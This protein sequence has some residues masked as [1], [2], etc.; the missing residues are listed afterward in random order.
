MITRF[1]VTLGLL[2][3]IPVKLPADLKAGEIGKATMFFPLVGLLI[4]FIMAVVWLIAWNIFENPLIAAVMVILSDFFITRGMHFDGL[5]DTADGVFSNR[6]PEEALMI[7]KDSRVGAMGVMAGIGA[8]FLKMALL[9]AIPYREGVSAIVMAA[10]ASRWS[11]VLNIFAYPYARKEPGTGKPFS[12][13]TGWH[14]FV[15][16][17]VI[18]IISLFVLG[19]WKAIL[20]AAGALGLAYGLGLFLKNKLGGLTGD[21]YGATNEIIFAGFLVLFIVVVKFL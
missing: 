18:A 11:M 5:M 13:Y 16:A 21:C 6:Q 14:E 3:C 15:I 12:D 4:G 1:L 9:A 7:M 19:S 8:A 17:T 10:V 2:T 20:A